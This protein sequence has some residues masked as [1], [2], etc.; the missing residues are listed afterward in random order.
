MGK[1]AT[2]RPLLK[3]AAGSG[4]LCA[5]G[6]FHWSSSSRASR[7]RREVDFGPL[8]RRHQNGS[9]PH[10]DRGKQQSP[11]PAASVERL[12]GVAFHSLSA[13]LTNIFWRI[14]KFR[15]NTTLKKRCPSTKQKCPW[16]Q[17]YRLFTVFDNGRAPP[18]PPQALSTGRRRGASL[19]EIFYCNPAAC[20]IFSVSPIRHSTP[21]RWLFWRTGA[22]VTE[23]HPG[24]M[25]KDPRSR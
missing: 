25:K 18:L 11:H 4:P 24:R 19:F 22:S 3:A 1:N 10:A 8:P 16:N 12:F 6:V 23:R 9:P 20:S 14:Y 17:C 2:I 7:Q 5:G 21:E 13:K 15:Y